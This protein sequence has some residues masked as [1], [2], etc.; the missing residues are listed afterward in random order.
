MVLALKHQLGRKKVSIMCLIVVEPSLQVVC[1]LH[2]VLHI[3][4]INL[5]IVIL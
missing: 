3:K 4:Y 2:F 5:C 1:F